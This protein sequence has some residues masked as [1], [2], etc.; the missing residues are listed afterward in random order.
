MKKSYKYIMG[1][2]PG[3]NGAVC[4]MN[5]QNINDPQI[6]IHDAPTFVEVKK[7]KGGKKRNQKNLDFYGMCNL[8]KP[9]KRYNTLFCIE[10]VHSLTGQGVASTFKFGVGYGVWQGAAYA[11]QFDIITISPQNWKKHWSDKLIQNLSKPKI[12]KDSDF[13]SLNT[14]QKMEYLK[15]QEEY[16]KEKRKSKERSKDLARELA[17]ELYPELSDYFKLKKHDGRAE[18]LLIAERQ[19][20]EILH[21]T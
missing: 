10:K 6:E 5:V 19:R 11:L 4:I 8:I 17:S 15:N 13:N 2:D 9:Y 21:G 7:L 12:L 1:V 16:G 20:Q 18:S 3:I 14:K